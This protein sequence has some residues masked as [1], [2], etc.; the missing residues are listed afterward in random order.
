MSNRLPF[1]AKTGADITADVFRVAQG[2]LER[3]RAA[4]PEGP[5]PFEVYLRALQ[6]VN[7]LLAERA[8]A[9]EAMAGLA[10]FQKSAVTQALQV[11]DREEDE[12]NSAGFFV[13]DG[14]GLGKTHVAGGVIKHFLDKKWRVLLLAPAATLRLTWR[15]HLAREGLVAQ[16]A[17]ESLHT[18]GDA[19]HPPA[20]LDRAA[21]FDL[22]V[23][24]ESHHLRNRTSS[25]YQQ[26][27]QLCRTP[28]NAGR[29]KRVLLLTA[30]PINNRIDD[31]VNQIYLFAGYGADLEGIRTRTLQAVGKDYKELREIFLDPQRRRDAVPE[32]L[33]KIMVRRERW[34][35]LEY[36]VKPAPQEAALA[37]G[38]PLAFLEQLPPRPLHYTLKGFDP[39]LYAKLEAAFR[40][41]HLP[42]I[43]VGNYLPIESVTEELAK[44]SSGNE[45][46]IV[47]GLLKRLES[48]VRAF[49]VS[50]Q[51]QV[52]FYELF[53]QD[54]ESGRHLEREALL[55]RRLW[56]EGED[57]E[58]EV[59]PAAFPIA[60]YETDRAIED[61]RQDIA[62][63]R[64]LLTLF[65]RLDKPTLDAKLATLQQQLEGFVAGR[66]ALI[67]TEFV[68][69]AEY[70]F[71]QLQP[72]G[73]VAL[74]TG[75]A[76][77]HG[78]SP[79]SE[80]SNEAIIR[81]FAPRANPAP[82]GELIEPVGPVDILVSTDV[83]AEGQNFQDCNI[84]INYDLTWN[85][86]RII[87]RVGRINRANSGE[88]HPP[89]DRKAHV[90][91]FFPED[92]LTDI[93]DECLTLIESN[94][95][96]L[97]QIAEIVGHGAAVLF[98]DEHTTR[99]L[100]DRLA[101]SQTGSIYRELEQQ[102]AQA[103]GLAAAF[104]DDELL[105]QE[106]RRLAARHPELAAKVKE[107][108]LPVVSCRSSAVGPP[109]VVG[110]YQE[111]V[112]ETTRLRWLWRTVEEVASAITDKSKSLVLRSLRCL[113]RSLRRPLSLD[114]NQIQGEC[115]QWLTQDLQRRQEARETAIAPAS[116][117]GKASFTNLANRIAAE[118][119]KLKP[120]D[121]AESAFQNQVTRINEWLAAVDQLVFTKRDA[122]S[123][124]V[125]ELLQRRSSAK[126]LFA[127][128]VEIVERYPVAVGAASS[129]VPPSWQLICAEEI[130][131]EGL[132][133]DRAG[134]ER[135]T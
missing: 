49:R 128:A 129:P 14:T 42:D 52:A 97:R 47:Q 19:L 79:S 51:R 37:G 12:R 70:L 108:A 95:R 101:Q 75:R 131:V 43:R 15:P 74:V 65:E 32:L 46:L 3:F 113:P 64:S 133:V 34:A 20:L 85:P 6:A 120:Q 25:R 84:V 82:Q 127:A 71:E 36:Y 87:Q 53:L 116:I 135:A 31:L 96:K 104:D 50:L 67:F 39:E 105:G 62:T 9:G 45:V 17:C 118:V 28:S 8:P 111:R 110:L 76:A 134:I 115:E 94:R 24:D 66:K 61:T 58:E 56:R 41:L 18:F 44:R 93:L 1:E 88:F 35:I 68:D 122:A 117:A 80:T 126:E 112:G 48:S 91:T 59:E 7:D 125:D 119:L 55:S 21:E 22:V 60:L 16:V 77:R 38:R 92:E 81:S 102:Q 54:L 132:P 114:V 99:I 4:A 73:K 107:L 23:I 69:T 89:E 100:F 78:D 11:L 10:D 30:A 130:R 106:Y 121:L 57:E 98:E 29:R 2:A 103:M 33:G 83:L 5:T 86:V 124:E 27:Q 40:R 13:C 26:I 63:L 90:L 72:R 109:G 123:A